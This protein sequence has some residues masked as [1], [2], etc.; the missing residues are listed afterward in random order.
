MHGVSFNTVCPARSLRLK[1]AEIQQKFKNIVSFKLHEYVHAVYISENMQM[2][3]GNPC[4]VHRLGLIYQVYL[5]IYQRTHYTGK[6][7]NIELSVANHAF[8]IH[9]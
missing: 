8:R 5:N 3:L 7:V 1:I 4:D 2:L 9:C 6:K